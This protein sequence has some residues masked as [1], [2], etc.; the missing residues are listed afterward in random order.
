MFRDTSDTRGCEA[1]RLIG[2]RL[3]RLG[4]RGTIA[5]T[6]TAVG[7]VRVAARTVNNL[8]AVGLHLTAHANYSRTRVRIDDISRKCPPMLTNSCDFLCDYKSGKTTGGSTWYQK[9]ADLLFGEK[10]SL[11]GLPSPLIV[12]AL[13]HCACRGGGGLGHP[14]LVLSTGARPRITAAAHATLEALET[15][16]ATPRLR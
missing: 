15:R 5:L 4:S 16:C 7:A 14:A 6:H 8:I 12:S 11:R 1:G 13:G 9:R 10:E 2:T 3:W